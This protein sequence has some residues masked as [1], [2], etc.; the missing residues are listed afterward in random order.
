MNKFNGIEEE[1]GEFTTVIA[2]IS[3][4]CYLLFV[5]VMCYVDELVMTYVGDIP[6][7][8]SMILKTWLMFNPRIPG[9]GIQRL[10]FYVSNEIGG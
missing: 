8:Y 1:I 3:C 2:P 6:F 4:V 7:Y 10:C 5:L 9:C